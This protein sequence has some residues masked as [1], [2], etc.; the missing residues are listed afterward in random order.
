MVGKGYAPFRVNFHSWPQFIRHFFISSFLSLPHICPSK[1]EN[2]PCMNERQS[3]CSQ[4]WPY[5]L[6]WF[7]LS[8]HFWF[9]FSSVVL[10]ILCWFVF[11]AFRHG[12]TFTFSRRAFEPPSPSLPIP[13]WH[14]WAFFSIVQV[15]DSQQETQ[16][17]LGLPPFQCISKVVCI[18]NA[19]TV[20][21]CTFCKFHSC[22]FLHI[23]LFLRKVH[24][25]LK[26][27]KLQSIT[28]VES[29]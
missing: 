12:S 15:L 28:P 20:R 9:V 7:F 13:S 24:P 5:A 26:A 1:N 27:Q 8:F 4:A 25:V 29:S 23:L 6:S 16:Q 10:K 14:V 18:S 21:R 17:A 2:I 11:C 19:K 22:W 3:R